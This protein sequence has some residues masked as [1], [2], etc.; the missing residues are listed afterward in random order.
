M[1]RSVLRKCDAL[2]DKRWFPLYGNGLC[3][4]APLIAK[5]GAGFSWRQILVGYLVYGIW[6]TGQDFLQRPHRK[7]EFQRFFCWLVEPK[8]ISKRILN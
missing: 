7:P 8:N 3:I 2:C 5:Y 1:K 4:A 6:Q